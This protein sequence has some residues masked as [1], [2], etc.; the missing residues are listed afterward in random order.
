[1]PALPKTAYNSTNEINRGGSMI[2]KGRDAGF[3]IAL[4]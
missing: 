1:M 3:Q 2:L 4:H